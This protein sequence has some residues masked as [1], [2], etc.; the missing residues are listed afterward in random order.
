MYAGAANAMG[1]SVDIYPETL[2]LLVRAA[3]E[4]GELIEGME[5]ILGLSL[6]HGQFRV[7]EAHEIARETLK[8][9]KVKPHPEIAVEAEVAII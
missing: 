8:A 3:K 6:D 4:R 5:K 9:L 7:S 1:D 2:A